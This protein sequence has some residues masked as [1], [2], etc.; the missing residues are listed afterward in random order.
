MKFYFLK[1]HGNSNFN[2]WKLTIRSKSCLNFGQNWYK[3][4]TFRISI[5]ITFRIGSDSQF[6]NRVPGSRI[7]FWTPYA[8]PQGVCRIAQLRYCQKSMIFF[9]FAFAK[10]QSKEAKVIRNELICPN[11]WSNKK[12][13]HFIQKYHPKAECAGTA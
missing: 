11:K 5:P 6:W 3:I 9:V 12:W 10:K 8:E 4:A 2:I 7:R 13:G 1:K